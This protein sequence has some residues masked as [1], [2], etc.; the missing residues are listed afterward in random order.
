MAADQTV[1][2][3]DVDVRPSKRPRLSS[4]PTSM[5][6]LPPPPPSCSSP[7]TPPPPSPEKPVLSFRPL[8]LP[9]LLLSLPAIL[10]LPPNHPLH[11]ESLRLSVVA[12]RKC[13]HIKALS[14]ET[15]C[16]AWA[17]LAQVGLQ[18]VGSRLSASSRE[19]H[20]WARNVEA[21]VRTTELPKLRYDPIHFQIDRAITKCVRLFF[22]LA[23]P[24]Y[25]CQSFCRA[26]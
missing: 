21:E 15:E 26:C 12:L 4:T 25:Q 23:F 1:S 11:D 18:V 16:R 9:L 7:L 8:P 10:I 22:L 24:L 13:L 2:E 19:R 14:P 17:T 6:G 3:L 20:A 5:S